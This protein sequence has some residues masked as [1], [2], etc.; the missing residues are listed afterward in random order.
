MRGE[1]KAQDYGIYHSHDCIEIGVSIAKVS[2]THPSPQVQ[3]GCSEI[4]GPGIAHQLHH[5]RHT[6]IGK[7][8]LVPQLPDP[9]TAVCIMGPYF[10]SD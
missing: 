8:S 10:N 9:S 1:F 5:P 4:K 7:P 3:P 6:Y 2:Q